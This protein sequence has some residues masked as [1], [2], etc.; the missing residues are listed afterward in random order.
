MARK[1]KQSPLDAIRASE[2]EQEQRASQLAALQ[3]ELEA[4]QKA[5]R[6]KLTNE[7]ASLIERYFGALS[8]E[9]LEKAETAFKA[10]L[11]PCTTVV[12]GADAEEDA[13]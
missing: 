10:F 9:T 6:E 4:A 12:Q 8:S 1:P 2:Q 11:Q 5:L 13:V 7:A 3:K